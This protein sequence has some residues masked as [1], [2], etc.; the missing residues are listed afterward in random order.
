MAHKSSPSPRGN[1]G[2]KKLFVFRIS[3]KL[4][5]YMKEICQHY[6]SAEKGYLLT[7]I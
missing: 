1:K 2:L 5:K 4:K 6:K 7:K 3:V